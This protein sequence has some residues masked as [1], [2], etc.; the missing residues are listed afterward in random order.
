[1]SM[2]KYKKVEKKSIILYMPVDMIAEIE[3]RKDKSI[4]VQECIR[5]ILADAI[6]ESK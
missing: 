5:R 1:M 3:K 4:S 2:E 6:K